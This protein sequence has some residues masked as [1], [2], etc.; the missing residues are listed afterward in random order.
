MRKKIKNFTKVLI[1]ATFI[2]MNTVIIFAGTG[3]YESYYEMYKDVVS[4]EMNPNNYIITTVWP[5][6]GTDG[7]DMSV[8]L[9]TKYWYGY[10]GPFQNI[11][12]TEG[13]EVTFDCNGT[14]HMVLWNNNPGALWT[15]NC[16]FYWR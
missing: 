10:D 6:Q 16:S 13:G 4:M 8:M 14:Y 1:C 2:I 11:S 9:G 15:G 7:C 3:Y 5:S 12:S